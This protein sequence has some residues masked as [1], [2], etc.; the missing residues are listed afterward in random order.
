MTAAVM[1]YGVV[2]GLL[3]VPAALLADQ[4]AAIRRSA[5]RWVWA[6]ALL[7]TLALP[8][9]AP[10]R[11]E[12]DGPA[13]GPIADAA[14]G[15]ARA[16]VPATW[17][18]V[19]SGVR[20][21]VSTLPFVL[22]AVEPWAAPIWLATSASVAFVYA[23]GYLVLAR[24]RR[25]WTRAI[26]QGSPVL[27][28]TD[29]GP[30]IVGLASPIVVLPRWTEQLDEPS[31][32]IILR[33][34]REHV[35]ARDPWL[36]HAT[37]LATLLMP[38][39]P[40]VWWMAARLRLAVEFDCDSRVLGSD[41]VAPG[42]V[43]R[44][45]ELLLA[46]ATRRDSVVPFAAPALIESSS[47][48]SRRIAAMCA[49]RVRFGRTKMIAAAVGALA[50]LVTA[51]RT[52][53]PAEPVNQAEPVER[54]EGSMRPGAEP[55]SVSD[56]SSRPD[57][58]AVPPGSAERMERAGPTGPEPTRAGGP[59]P[60]RETA[61]VA[62]IQAPTASGLD[63]PDLRRSGPGV[64]N[65]RVLRDVRPGYTPAAMRAKIQGHV[66]LEALVGVDGLVTDVRVTKS[67]D[68]EF[69]LDEAA[70]TAAR[71]WRFEPALLDGKP[72]PKTVTLVLSFTIH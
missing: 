49:S 30:A 43:A 10:W 22:A 25:Q 36:V 6:W 40:A 20:N 58:A 34:E 18:V 44:Y 56:P 63:S 15:A 4:T 27:L 61:P 47:S 3:L 68:K 13:P 41:A 33:H 46:V 23:A 16:G 42:D 14:F 51:C 52:P 59:S 32:S 35:D 12:A 11:A 26:V 54:A 50:L 5:R 19:A 62:T 31:L 17:T 7:I 24:R 69:G 60:G 2:V 65:P 70:V 37:G 8:V 72:V 39:N 28:A 29:T 66:E 71:A 38:W 9:V 48:L 64:S 67:L 57:G 1:F 53:L 45:G 55:T 21:G